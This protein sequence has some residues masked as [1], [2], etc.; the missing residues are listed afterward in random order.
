MRIVCD[1]NIV[2]RFLI[3]D[4]PRHP[5]VIA[6]I[7]RLVERGDQLLYTPQVVRETYHTLMR[8]KT[9]N[10]LELSLEDSRDAL[11]N[12]EDSPLTLLNDTPDVYLSWRDIVRTVEVRGR[13]AHDA[14]LAAA[15]SA[16][17]VSQLLT[18]DRRDFA[19]YPG[20]AVLT[21]DSVLNPQNP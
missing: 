7:D 13:Q 2:L 15:M 20:L 3:E 21:P 5:L 10:G 6:T 18:M 11:T 14:N 1:A 12:L 8:P 17:G 4:D 19:R 16:H 9:G